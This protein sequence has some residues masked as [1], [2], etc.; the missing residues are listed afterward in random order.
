LSCAP[1]RFVLAGFFQPIWK[2]HYIVYS[3]AVRPNSS[4]ASA[5]I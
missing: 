5:R 4:T 1:S 2:H 3:E